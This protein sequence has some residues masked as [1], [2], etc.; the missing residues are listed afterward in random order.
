LKTETSVSRIRTGSRPYLIFIHVQLH[1]WSVY[2]DELFVTF[3]LHKAPIRETKIRWLCTG[4]YCGGVAEDPGGLRLVGDQGR[5][6]G[7]I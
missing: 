3:V 5:E 4:H 7:S 1:W 2:S 6:A